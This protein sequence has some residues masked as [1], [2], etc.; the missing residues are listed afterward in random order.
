[1]NKGRTGQVKDSFR[2]KMA[3]RSRIQRSKIQKNKRERERITALNKHFANLKVY[4]PNR[5]QITTKAEILQ[6]AVEY[7]DFLEDMVQDFQEKE[8]EKIETLTEPENRPSCRYSKVSFYA[9]EIFQHSFTDQR[10]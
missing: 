4:L 2:S 3:E 7:I 6:S 5:N 10:L 1:M 8:L 9:R